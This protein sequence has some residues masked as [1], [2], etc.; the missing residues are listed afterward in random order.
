MVAQIVVGLLAAILIF[1]GVDGFGCEY[2]FEELIYAVC[3]RFI[4]FN[5]KLKFHCA[6]HMQ[7]EFR[8]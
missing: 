4:F 3:L 8:T 5:K 7:Q 2:N 6:V 1:I